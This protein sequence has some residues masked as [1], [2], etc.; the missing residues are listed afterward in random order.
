M[1]QKNK[2][3]IGLFLICLSTLAFELLQTR[4]LSVIYFHHVVYLT[5]TIALM[6]FGISGAFASI[7]SKKLL[8]NTSKYLTLFSGLFSVSIIL[9]IIIISYSV[10]LFIGQVTIKKLIFSYTI[11]I[12]PFIF[13]GLVICLLL[14]SRSKLIHRLY[15]TDLVASGMGTALFIALIGQ[16]GGE[17]FVFFLAIMSA[18]AALS[19]SMLKKENK[20]T[21]IIIILYIFLTFIGWSTSKKSII[22]IKPEDYK[23]MAQIYDEIFHPDAK[24]ERIK[25]TPISRIEILSDPT[26]H[27]AVYLKESSPDS[28]RMMTVDGDSHTLIH[29]KRNIHLINN[30]IKENNDNHLTNVVYRLKN[31]PEVLVIGVGGG[32]DII[33]ALSYKAKNVIGLELN[34]AIYNFTKNVYKD[35]H[36]D[37]FNKQNITLINDEGRSYLRRCSK[38]FDIIQISAIDT[39]AALSSGAYVLSENY[40]YTVEAFKDYINHLK[41]NGILSI[42]RWF[43]KEKPRETLR[44]SSL[45]IEAYRELNILNPEKHVAII[46]GPGWASS[47]FKKS[48]FTIDEIKIIEDYTKRFNWTVLFF[49]KIL[50]PIKQKIHENTYYKKIP[51]RKLLNDSKIFNELFQSY[52]ENKLKEF[53]NNYS[54]KVNPV[55]DDRPFFFEYNK[56]NKK[57]SSPKK[58]YIELLRGNISNFV[59]Y[60]LLIEILVITGV[61]IIWPLWRHYKEGL[62]VKRKYSIITYFSALG[63]GFMFIEISLMQKFVLFLGHPIYSIS[64]VLTSMLIFSGIGSYVAGKFPLK[65]VTTILISILA[66]SIIGIINLFS[67]PKI[68]NIFLKYTVSYRI[69]IS[70]LILAPL[71]F[72]MGMPFPSGL[73]VVDQVSKKLIPWAWGINGASSVLSSVVAIILAL[74]F[75]F[76]FVLFLAIMIYAIGGA[77]F[78]IRSVY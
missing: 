76:S 18:L 42:Y 3:F 17:G 12:I 43:F 26:S 39:F 67:L 73:R 63:I 50:P 61:L 75:G 58:G 52:K 57:N 1:R 56:F 33:S 7:Y 15:F 34:P 37:F 49:P 36:G 29:S 11:L 13:S 35:F 25:W 64:V 44:L 77:Q 74:N 28:Y 4:I 60:V 30:K 5:V 23:W 59:L 51:D 2:L 53:Y 10:N 21:Q 70:I 16:I 69:L 47:L 66:I 9:S 78:Y 72:F 32:V 40:L 14:M 27:L 45:G 62:R 19:F 6:G 68:F 71:S 46:G 65:F 48:E 8:S 41:N 55:Y 22:N 20:R 24:L 38:E 31:N 54:Y